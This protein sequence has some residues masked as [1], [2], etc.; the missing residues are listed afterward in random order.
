MESKQSLPVCALCTHTPICKNQPQQSCPYFLLKSD[1]VK[2]PKTEPKEIPPPPPKKS[3]FRKLW[4]VCLWVIVMSLMGGAFAA[5]RFSTRPDIVSLI[6]PHTVT[7]IPG[8]SP[9]QV[10]QHFFQAVQQK[11]VPGALALCH[12]DLIKDD[13]DDIAANVKREELYK[14]QPFNTQKVEILKVEIEESARVIVT[15]TGK[16]GY[17]KGETFELRKHQGQWLIR[18]F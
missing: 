10:V 8:A 11:D 13:G 4:R 7:P 14:Y 2:R 15:M 18:D 12:P 5:G 3:F 9:D 17:T 16:N 6:P 1:P